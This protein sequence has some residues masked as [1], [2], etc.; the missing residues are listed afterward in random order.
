MSIDI[1]IIYTNDIFRLQ[2]SDTTFGALFIFLDFKIYNVFLPMNV[3]TLKYNVFP[4]FWYIWFGQN[5]TR[6]IYSTF[7]KFPSRLSLGELFI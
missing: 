6:S 3:S 7:L 4:T 5:V 1:D 2:S